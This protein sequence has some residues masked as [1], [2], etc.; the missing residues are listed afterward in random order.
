MGWNAGSGLGSTNEGRVE[1]IKVQQFEDRA[2]LGAAK[3][4]EAGSWSGPGGWQKRAKDMVSLD[5]CRLTSDTT[6]L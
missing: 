1:P 5:A 2:G 6:T 3:G 4:R